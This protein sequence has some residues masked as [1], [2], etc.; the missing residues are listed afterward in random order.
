M[1]VRDALLLGI[2]LYWGEGA[3][4]RKLS[5]SNSNPDMLVFMVIWFKLLGVSSNDFLVRVYINESHRD[6]HRKVRNFW[7]KTLG[8]PV[9]QFYEP[10]FIKA[11]LRKVYENRET[12]YGVV[13]LRIRR[14]TI[15]Q[16]R[17][18]GLI[19]SVNTADVAQ[20]VRAQHS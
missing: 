19:K 6:R 7:I 4:G 10:T 12:Y 15:L 1:S 14:S 11:S 17:I 20:L 8:I 18:L 2:G 9:E 3:K 5:F 16:D 13:A